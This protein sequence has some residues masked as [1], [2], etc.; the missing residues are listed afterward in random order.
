MSGMTHERWKQIERLQWDKALRENPTAKF[1][2]KT[3]RKLQ[4][5]LRRSMVL[6]HGPC[7]PAPKA[8]GLKQNVTLWYLKRKLAAIEKE[9]N[10][11]LLK[12][13]GVSLGY[14]LLAALPAYNLA[15]AGG[16]TSEEWGAVG[17]AFVMAMWG[18]FSSNT[19]VA[20][21]SRKGETIRGPGA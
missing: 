4:K 17:A 2:N 18:K 8:L 11:G 20:M 14:G 6:T 12:K 10:M 5:N 9:S 16:M 13:I 19:T 1:S 21:P 3:F 15:A 7:P